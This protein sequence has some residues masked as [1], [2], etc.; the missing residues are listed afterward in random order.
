MFAGVCACF[1]RW[2]SDVWQ[3]ADAGASWEQSSAAAFP[4]REGAFATAV[5]NG[6][7]AVG[8]VTAVSS[9]SS[10]V[11]SSRPSASRSL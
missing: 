4:G 8:P 5:R 10:R 9:A 3:S 11:A 2:L 7:A 6:S 1:D